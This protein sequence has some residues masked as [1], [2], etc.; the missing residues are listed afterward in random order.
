[1]K[2]P[3]LAQ[4]FDNHRWSGLTYRF[5]LV[6]GVV[7]FVLAGL[8]TVISRSLER[9]MLSAAL[10]RQAAHVADLLVANVANP[11]FTFN[12]DGIVTVANAFGG[13]PMIRFLEIK[14][15]SGKSIATSGDRST[16]SSPS[17]EEGVSGNNVRTPQEDRR[18]AARRR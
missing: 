12:R 15:P 18:R 3:T 1:M 7:L 10:E 6:T 16:A 13:N 4:V 2:V 17:S 14:D 5:T 8:S 9:D 11:L